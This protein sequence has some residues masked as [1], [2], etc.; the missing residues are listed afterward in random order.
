MNSRDRVEIQIVDWPQKDAGSSGLDLAERAADLLVDMQSH[1]AAP[2]PPRADI[3]RTLLSLPAGARMLLAVDGQRV[4]GVACFSAIFPGPGL[5]SGFFLKDL[6][7]A[8]DRR[9]HGI[10][11]ALMSRLAALAKCEG[12]GRIDLTMDADDVRLQRYYE[13]LGATALPHKR[14]VRIMGDDLAALAGARR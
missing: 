5:T 7:V 13:A 9:G 12:H 14:F 2:C 3:V 4:V 6:F 11:R 10:G 8:E 1:Y